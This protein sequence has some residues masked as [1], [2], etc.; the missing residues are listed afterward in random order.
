MRRVH[1]N[2]V[3]ESFLIDHHP[4]HSIKSYDG[5]SEFVHYEVNTAD[6]HLIS[7]IARKQTDP[8]SLR[9]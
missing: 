9:A 8:R 5:E 3:Y 2:G 4:Y 7:T 6:E 1:Y